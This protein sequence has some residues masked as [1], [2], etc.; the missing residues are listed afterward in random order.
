MSN[1]LVLVTGAAGGQQ[2]QTGRHVSEMLLARGIPVR[3][4]VHRIDKRSDHLRTLG[5]EVL[6]GDFLDILSVQ[7]AVRRLQHLFRLPGPGW[8]ARRHR[9]HGRRR[10]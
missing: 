5:A 1:R 8:V 7:R 2:G 9:D 6:E 4:F 3:A 10:T